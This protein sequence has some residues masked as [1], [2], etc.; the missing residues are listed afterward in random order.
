MAVNY[1]LKKVEKIEELTKT[2]FLLKF[3]VMLFNLPNQ[4]LDQ[5]QLGRKP[6][7]LLTSS[8]FY[9]VISLFK[10]NLQPQLDQIPNLYDRY[11]NDIWTINGA[12]AKGCLY[13]LEWW[14]K[15][16]DESGL[17]LKYTKWGINGASA[18]GHVE[19]SDWWLKARDESGLEFKYGEW[20][21]N[22]A[23]KYGHVKVLDWWLKAR[24]ESGL[25]LK[26]DRDAINLASAKGHVKVLDWWKNSGLELKYT[27]W[28]I[29][30]AHHRNDIKVLEW[31]KNSGLE[32]PEKVLEYFT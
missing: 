29:S 7:K 1:R 27:E 19:V 2:Y 10:V 18:N 22:Y 25:E 32:L 16:R 9:G 23:S 13:I 24:D 26:Y 3:N 31:W 4:L 14:L 17:K 6:L 21:L 30:W 28:G 15:A 5:I 11:A 20:A 12:S 8:K